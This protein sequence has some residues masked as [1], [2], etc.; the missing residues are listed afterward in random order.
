MSIITNQMISANSDMGKQYENFSFIYL[1]NCI[2]DY[3]SNDMKIW[4][5]AHL[6]IKQLWYESPIS[7][8][9]NLGTC[10]FCTVM[11]AQ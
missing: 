7:E 6:V 2:Y 10:P 3:K 9:E 11:V 5:C 1:A 4:T 8:Y